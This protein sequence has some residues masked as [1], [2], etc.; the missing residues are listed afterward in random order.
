MSLLQLASEQ[1]FMQAEHD[2]APSLL[3][4]F[5]FYKQT[6]QN[7]NLPEIFIPLLF[8]FYK[9]HEEEYLSYIEQLQ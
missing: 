8:K 6:N 7:A 4:I 1:L 3:L 9:E 2:P 5:Y